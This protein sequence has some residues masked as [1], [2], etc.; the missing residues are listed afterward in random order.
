MFVDGGEGLAFLELAVLHRL[1][2][3]GPTSP[4]ALAN[5]EGVTGA[6]VAAALTH[7]QSLGLVGRSKHPVD[8]RRA[9]VAISDAGRQALNQRD[10]ALLERIHEVLRDHLDEHD[11]TQLAAAIPLLEKVAEKL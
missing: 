4:G 11:R 2:A 7:L 5:D 9:I 10:S 6:A 3:S 8:G 1:A